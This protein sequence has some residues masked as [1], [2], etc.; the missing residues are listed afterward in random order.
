MDVQRVSVLGLLLFTNMF[1]YES[2]AHYH[3]PWVSVWQLLKADE[4]M[5]CA[6]SMKELLMYVVKWKSGMEASMRVSMG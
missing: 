6:T 4:P 3:F 5:T 1:C 2:A